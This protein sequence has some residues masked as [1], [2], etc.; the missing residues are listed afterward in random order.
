MIA[1]V[2]GPVR[3]I[4]QS[5]IAP[6]MQG[7]VMSLL[8]SLSSAMSPIGLMIAGPV[9]DLLGIR[10]WFVFAGVVTSLVGVA[11]FFMPP[12]LRLEDGRSPNSA[13]I[14][15]VG[16]GETAVTDSLPA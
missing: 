16:V 13:T 9:A 1:M 12:L 11:G 8:V 7:R 14:E 10:V 3:A 5:V 4:M 15:Q 6:E 2:N